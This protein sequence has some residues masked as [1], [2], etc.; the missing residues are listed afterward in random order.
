M[1]DLI[2]PQRSKERAM[3]SLKRYRTTKGEMERILCDITYPHPV[4]FD[5]PSAR[6][7]KRDLKS[8][9][10]DRAEEVR[11]IL[12][13]MESMAEANVENSRLRDYIN[14]LHDLHN[15]FGF[16]SAEGPGKPHLWEV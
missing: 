14:A 9:L 13:M 2:P 15:A 10:H 12:D 8:M 7:T 5:R 11:R 3:S 6:L 1:T 4:Y 16:F